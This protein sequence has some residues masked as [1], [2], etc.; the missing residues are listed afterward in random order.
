MLA[1]QLL[2]ADAMALTPSYTLHLA[3]WGMER[4]IDVR[5]SSVKRITTAGEPGGGEPAMRSK[6]EELWGARVTEAGGVG[7]IC[8]SIWGECEEQVGMHFGA[9]GHLHV[10]LINPETGE[11]VDMKDG[12]EGELVYTHLEHEGAPLLRF[13]T[14]DH[15][16]VWTSTCAC[17]RTS[18]R[19]RIIG[20][21][22]DML[23]V[24]GVNIFPS[25]IREVVN[26]FAPI[27]SGVISVRPAWKGFKQPAPLKVVVELGEAQAAPSDLAERIR[28]AIRASLLVTT[29]IHLVA[30]G[31]LPRSEYKSKLTDYSEAVVPDTES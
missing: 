26:R 2:K 19:V 17:G 14:R 4:G 6:L 9:R 10:E 13:R 29:D 20:R 11:P 23:I 30:P 8:V 24:R 7:D 1:V 16:K 18:P 27:V 28:N 12:A 25:A 22:D 15:V 3:E 5:N 31:T 21:T